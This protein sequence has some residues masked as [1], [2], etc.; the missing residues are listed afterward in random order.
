VDQDTEFLDLKAQVAAQTAEMAQLRARLDG[1]AAPTSVERVSGDSGGPTSRRHLLKLVGA[2]AVGAAGASLLSAA[3]AGATTGTMMFGVANDAGSDST[4]L[5]STNSFETLIVGNTAAGSAAVFG[6]N[7]GTNSVGVFGFGNGTGSTGVSGEAPSGYGVAAAGLLAPLLLLPA[8]AP[9][10][11]T[12]NAHQLGEVFVDSNGALFQCV[13]PGTPGIWVR[14]GF[15]PLTPVRILDTRNGPGPLTGGQTANL[16]VVGNNG[17][18]FQASAVVMNATVTDTTDASFLTI[19]PQGV[20]RPLASNLNWSAGQ[21]IANLVTVKLG[22][23][24]SIS[25][26]NNVGDVQVIVDLAGFYS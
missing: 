17:V 6:I 1:S 12:T 3:P 21:T 19:Y 9:G 24:G 5:D 18:P 13:A 20:T 8:A 2:A 16:Q 14:I 22:F 11:P 10:P 23:E 7:S 26:F 25:I 4:E 15:N